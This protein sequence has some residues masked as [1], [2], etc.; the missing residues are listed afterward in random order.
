MQAATKSPIESFNSRSRVGSDPMVKSGVSAT[1][2]FQ[3]TL[4]CR[5]RHAYAEAIGAVASFNSRSR[6]GSDWRRRIPRPAIGVF[7]FTLP[8]RERPEERRA[9][10]A[11]SEFQFT[12]PCRERLQGLPRPGL[13]HQVSIPSPV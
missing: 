13:P 2:P 7:Q 5:E 9:A 11:N 12:L 6:V 3:F 4:P 10:I 8:C 1:A